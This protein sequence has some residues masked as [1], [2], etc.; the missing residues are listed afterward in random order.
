MKY[1]I[2]NDDGD[3]YGGFSSE[4]SKPIWY[5]TR[6]D[7]CM[8]ESEALV[9]TVIRQLKALGF[10]KVVKRDASGVIRKWVPADLDA[11]VV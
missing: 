9:D 11:T 8:I 6:R 5:K 2:V 4:A 1:V 3:L 7:V 10:E